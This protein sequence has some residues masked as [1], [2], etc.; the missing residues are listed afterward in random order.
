MKENNAQKP[1]YIHIQTKKKPTAPA[2]LTIV[3]KVVEAATTIE[4]YNVNL[5][6]IYAKKNRN[7]TEKME[8]RAL[9]STH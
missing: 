6:D 7:D 3:R 8:S 1:T 2:A 5:N 9:I 4:K